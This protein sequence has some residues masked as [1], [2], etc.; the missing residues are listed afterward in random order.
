MRRAL[1]VLTILLIA[2][3][4]A[5]S[6]AAGDEDPFEPYIV[7]GD[8]TT[9][10]EWPAYAQVHFG[11][12]GLSRADSFV[13]GATVVTDRLV[14]TAAHCAVSSDLD[15]I[16]GS[17]R[18]TSGGTRVHVQQII[19]HPSYENLG[20]DI[21]LLKLATAVDIDE[22]AVVGPTS[23]YRWTGGDD[24]LTVI[25]LGCT[26]PVRNAC[27]TDGA[28]PVLRRADVPSRLDND[29]E[30][31]VSLPS[32]YDADTML[33]AGELAD[34]FGSHTA[35]GACYGDSGG[36]LLAPGHRGEHVIVGTV[37]WG[38][39]NC[40]DYPVVYARLASYRTW[41]RDNGV[42]VDRDPYRDGPSIS[43]NGSYTPIVGDYNGDGNDD[44]LY[45]GPG[46]GSDLMRLG[47]DLGGFVSG[48]AISITGTYTP[49]A[50]DFNGDGRTD[51]FW[52]RP[53]TQTDVIRLGTPSGGFPTGPAI[54]IDG[55]YTPV[56]GD[57]NGDGRGD[58]LLYAPGNDAD[59][60]RLGSPAGS[61]ST[62]PAVSVN[63]TYDRGIV[64]DY[65]GDGNDDIVWYDAGSSGDVTRLANDDGSF[66]SGPAIS[67]TGIFMPIAGEFNSDG[68]TDILWYAAGTGGD[69]LR[70]A[71][72]SAS[73]TTGPEVVVNATGFTPFGGDFNGDGTGDVFWYRKGSATDSLWLGNPA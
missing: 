8:E 15:V 58:M 35:P 24:T 37:S 3:P 51:I 42:P 63:A 55:A 50:G 45:Y 32:L 22:F 41:L 2:G 56:A 5:G 73:F 36:A 30:D 4:T 12:N 6:A 23:D 10:E 54:D 68:R 39:T 64:G 46:D 71:S 26:E 61:F 49:L 19:V 66:V 62:G 47:N 72:S 21:A 18:L 44:V 67:V 38:A 57:F 69:L 48:P 43:V 28:S 33:C 27:A 52:Y 17:D 9:I 53:G 13:C 20:N 16:V 29:C 60:M 31:L 70:E 11:D 40:G 59:L 14:L 65:N 25:G 7:N 34:P 1:T